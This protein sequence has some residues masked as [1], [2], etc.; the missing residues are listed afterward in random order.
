VNLTAVCDDRLGGWGKS[1]GVI[2]LD[3][4]RKPFVTV[5]FNILIDKLIKYSLGKWAVR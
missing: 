5:S 1:S 4:K 2:C 3:F